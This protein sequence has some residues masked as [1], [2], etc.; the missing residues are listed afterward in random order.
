ML[1]FFQILLQNFPLVVYSIFVSTFSLR[2]LLLLLIRLSVTFF[3]FKQLF[4]LK[5][6]HTAFIHQGIYII[7]QHGNMCAYAEARTQDPRIKSQTP[8]PLSYRPDCIVCSDRANKK[9]VQT[10]FYCR[11]CEKAMCPTD[12][13]M[14]YH[15]RKVFR[16]PA[17]NN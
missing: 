8:L 9:R 1:S 7:I 16:T 2:T 15:T 11:N 4:N 5:V 17:H 6:G 13:F 10:R 12:C 3:I 14:V